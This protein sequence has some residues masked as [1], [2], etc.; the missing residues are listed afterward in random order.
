[1]VKLMNQDRESTGKTGGASRP[2]PSTEDLLD[3]FSSGDREAA[4]M[5]LDRLYTELHAIARG[6]MRRERE[7][8]T[9]QP[10]ALV[11]EAYIRLIGRG[12]AAWKNK[13]HFLGS[14]A[15]TMRRILVDHAR[16]RLAQKRGGGDVRVTLSDN[17][18]ASAIQDHD[19]LAVH[20]ALEKLTKLSERQAKVIDLRFFAGLS[21][22]ETAQ[23]LGI[24][25]RTVKAESRMA[26]AWL[27][28]ELAG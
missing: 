20:E 23:V 5:L 25:T 13:A 15:R 27:R 7:G 16:R 10:T 9:L 18:P 17:I 14:A 22:E 26:K 2:L 1:M 21:V 6:Y 8:H 3:L 19:M 12:G 11:N 28:R 24:S 4:A